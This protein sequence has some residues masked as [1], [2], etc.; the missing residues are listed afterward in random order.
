MQAVTYNN[1]IYVGGKYR[2]LRRD[3]EDKKRLE[4]R[5]CPDQKKSKK[6]KRK[7]NSRMKQ[8]QKWKLHLHRG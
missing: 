6:G 8:K 1:T 3:R 4:L 5:H 2:K 7:T